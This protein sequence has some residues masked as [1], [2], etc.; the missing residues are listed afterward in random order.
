VRRVLVLVASVV[1]Q[2]CLGGVYAWSVFVPPLRSECGLSA[3][4][5]QTIFGWTIAS[6]A[7]AM[8]VAGRLQDRRGPRLV[9]AVG[10]VLYA[11]GYL[12]GS[13]SGGSFGWLLLGIGGLSGAGIGFGYVCPLATCIKWFPAHK[14]LIT[15]VS[16][17]GFGGGAIVLSWFAEWMFS[18]GL[19][20]LEVFR[21][22]GLLYGMVLLAGAAFLTVPPGSEPSG[23]AGVSLPL[24]RL[25][26]ERDF[27]AP[28]AGMFAGTFAGLLVVGNLKPIALAG[29]LSA[30]VASTGVGVLA[31]G[32]A[33]GRV[34]WGRVYDKLGV[35]AMLGSLAF[36]GVWVVGLLLAG[37]H[38]LVYM[39][40]CAMV[41]FG[42]GAC[43]VLYAAYVA[44]AYGN[45]VFGRIYPLVFLAYGVSA[46]V[47]PALGGW[48][49]D[50]TGTF[51]GA[52]VIASLL[53]L[54][55]AFVWWRLV[56]RVGGRPS[57]RLQ[58]ALDVSPRR[59]LGG[60][61]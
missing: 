36:L 21:S 28:V 44:A 16:V 12:V 18:Q 40:L 60:G 24:G 57:P 6:F 48:L 17:A 35:L 31:V 11:S 23:A 2:A 53:S 25:L 52:I 49:F 56:C 41:G 43:F 8:I 27:W 26:R 13:V 32:N 33:L 47:G 1:I 55:G 7:L 5:T 20:V 45:E 30:G 42:F 61:D 4:E 37:T 50:L 10:A 58:G 29:G 22:I 19:G 51:D 39:I 38:A 54:A 9:A 14:G 3:A 59:V 34:V 15:G 46:L